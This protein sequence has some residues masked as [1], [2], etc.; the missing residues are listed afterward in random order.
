MSALA[1]AVAVWGAHYGYYRFPDINDRPWAQY[2]GTHAALALALLLLAPAAARVRASKR[3]SARAAAWLATI[4]L[5]SCYLG[6]IESAQCVACGL[7][8]WGRPVEL[9]LCL[10]A[11]GATP[12]AIAAAA[13]LA[14][15]LV[16]WWRARHG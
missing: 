16:R 7:H 8:E 4:G 1:L 15:M 9:D 13:L 12:Y 5:G 3:V 14:T 11:F 10:Q 2:V 6:A